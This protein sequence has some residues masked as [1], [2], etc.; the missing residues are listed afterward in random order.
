MCVQRNPEDYCAG[1]IAREEEE[2]AERVRVQHRSVSDRRSGQS[3]SLRNRH[4]Y[5]SRNDGVSQVMAFLS[6]LQG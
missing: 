2:K 5:T 1:R 6:L 4:S 3:D